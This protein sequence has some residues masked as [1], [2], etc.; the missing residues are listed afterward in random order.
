MIHP[1]QFLS[2]SGA[3]PRSDA[4]HERLSIT[5]VRVALRI[6]DGEKLKPR[7][8]GARPMLTALPL[9]LAGRVSSAAAVV[10]MNSR[11]VIDCVN[12]AAAASRE[13]FA[14]FARVLLEGGESESLEHYQR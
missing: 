9:A 2:G 13:P 5:H 4:A 1:L 8:L 14:R 11:R 7:L 6:T 10:I 12:A 3:N